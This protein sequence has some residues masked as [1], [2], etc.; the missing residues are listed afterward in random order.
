VIPLPPL[1]P[2]LAI[3][4]GTAMAALLG[5]IAGALAIRRQ[6]IYF[7]MVTLALPDG[8]CS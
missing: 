8:P 4:G 5:L 1:P 3:L 2:E 7:A 6:G